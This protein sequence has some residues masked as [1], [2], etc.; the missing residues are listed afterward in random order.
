MRVPLAPR[1]RAQLLARDL[2]RVRAAL[3]NRELRDWLPPITVYLR[4][5]D[6]IEVLGRLAAGHQPYADYPRASAAAVGGRR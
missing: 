3:Q 2:R 6:L 5:P 4:L 1:R